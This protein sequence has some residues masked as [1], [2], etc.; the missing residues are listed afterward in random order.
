[1]NYLTRL[2]AVGLMAANLSACGWF[3][4]EVEVEPAPLVKFEAE[5]DVDLLWRTSVGSLGEKFNQLTMG[6]TTDRIYTSSVSG[7]VYALDRASGDVVWSAE[8][9]VPVAGGVGVG[10]KQIAVTTE[11]GM[12]IV[13]N[14]ENGEEIWR[15][16]LQ[17]EALS[18]AQ[19]NEQLLVSQLQN[20][21][22]VAFDVNTGEQ[23]WTYDT[24]IPALTLRGTS[25]P[26]V[27]LDATL[28][29]F[30]NGK[31]VAVDNRN[32]GLLWERLIA[33]ADGKSELERIIDIDGQPIL[34]NGVVYVVSYQGKLVAV[35]V[36]DAQVLWSK[37]ASSYR[38]L[39]AGFGNIYV[40]EDNSFIQAYDQRTSAS[41][42]QQPALELREA[43]APAVI[44]NTVVVGD[45]DGYL[46]FMSQIDGRFV[47]RYQVDGSGIRS[48]M[49]V[50]DD[51]LYVLTNAG[52]LAAIK[53]Q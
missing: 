17:A 32:G 11:Q 5:K 38:Q 1:M 10:P 20:G 42:W 51:T 45:F 30:A 18:P 7:N 49:K 50:V 3:S 53:L 2:A 28:A 46:H 40:S 22:L 16:Q 31:L 13:L 41:V 9:D 8:L 37:D 33:A 23:K 24:Q 25:A 6:I 12:L 21:S 4:S 43:S 15:K 34:A 14:N 52:R 44:G 26:I 47:A 39:A 29:A 19:M 27:A 48:D 35:S 36:Q